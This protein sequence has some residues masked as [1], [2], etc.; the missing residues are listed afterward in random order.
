MKNDLFKKSIIS[1]NKLSGI[2]GGIGPDSIGERDTK[3]QTLW[4]FL[5]DDR[6][7]YTD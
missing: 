5:S 3:R 1:E 7:F 2:V 4:I 6:Q